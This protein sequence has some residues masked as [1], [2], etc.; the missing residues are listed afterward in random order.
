MKRSVMRQSLHRENE[1][2]KRN[3]HVIAS[4][5]YTITRNDDNK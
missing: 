4:F 5:H 1:Y 2:M 3:C